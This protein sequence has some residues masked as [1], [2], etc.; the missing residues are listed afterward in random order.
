MHQIIHA[1]VTA[2]LRAVWQPWLVQHQPRL[3]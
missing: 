2:A 1:W 3:V